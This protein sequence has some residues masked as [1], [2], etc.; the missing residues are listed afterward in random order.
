M[1]VVENDWQ[2]QYRSRPATASEEATALAA[3]LAMAALLDVAE[4][5][6]ETLAA[7]AADPCDCMAHRSPPELLRAALDR[8][9]AS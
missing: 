7:M 9:D 6:R 5:A 2:E 3:W 4:A 8:L 1:E